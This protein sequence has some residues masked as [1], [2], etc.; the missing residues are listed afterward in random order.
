MCVM[1]V[2]WVIRRVVVAFV[3][4]PFVVRAG[5][6]LVMCFVPFVVVGCAGCMCRVCV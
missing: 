5:G 4:L 2:V 3:E 1:V 6:A